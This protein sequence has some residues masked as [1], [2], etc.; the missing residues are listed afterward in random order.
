MQ[1]TAGKYIPIQTEAYI[2]FSP[3][4]IYKTFFF[5]FHYVSTL[6]IYNYIIYNFGKKYPTGNAYCDEMQR[7]KGQKTLIAT[8]TSW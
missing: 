8:M 1:C 2:F 6:N 7:K 4:N 3:H 5:K